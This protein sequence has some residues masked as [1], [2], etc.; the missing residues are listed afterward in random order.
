MPASCVSVDSNGVLHQDLTPVSSCSGYVMVTPADYA[1]LQASAEP[2]D[3]T[4]ASTLWT[5]AFSSVL[6]CWFVSKSAGTILGL[7]RKG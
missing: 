7:I 6:L 3:Y 1:N 5:A 4:A 2:I